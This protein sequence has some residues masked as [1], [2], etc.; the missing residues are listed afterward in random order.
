M[1]KGDGK[2]PPALPRMGLTWRLDKSLENVSY[3]G[4]G[5]EENYVDRCTGSFLGLWKDTVTGMY[6]PYVR[7]QDCGYRAGVRWIEL[8]DDSGRGVRFSADQ[9]LFAQTLHF[10]M[11]DLEFARHRNGQPRIQNMPAARA[12]VMLNLDVRQLGLGGA[13]CG[14]KPMAKYIFPI[15]KTTWTVTIEPVGKKKFLGLF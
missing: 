8:T 5:P 1:R 9:P 10:T 11:E 7:P 4:R 12:E 15:E 3:Y 14:P 13:S 6:E 2:M